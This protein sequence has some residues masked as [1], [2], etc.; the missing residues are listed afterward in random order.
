MTLIN[1]QNITPDSPSSNASSVYTYLKFS[2][3]YSPDNNIMQGC[4]DLSPGYSVLYQ[5]PG[6]GT[7]KTTIYDQ[8]ISHGQTI[9]LL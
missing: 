2:E 4:V 1:L 8:E 6:V 5:I 9:K 7:I 3:D